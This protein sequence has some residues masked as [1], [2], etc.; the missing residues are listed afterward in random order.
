M[1]VSTGTVGESA[2]LSAEISVDY[3]DWTQEE[4]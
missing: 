2:V 3:M 4:G 1:L